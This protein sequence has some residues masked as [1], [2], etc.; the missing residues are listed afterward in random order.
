MES[1][2]RIADGIIDHRNLTIALVFI[3]LLAVSGGIVF[4]E[5]ESAMPSFTVGSDEE[6]ALD[7]IESNF[8]TRNDDVTVAQIIV[9]GENVLSKETLVSTLELQQELRANETVAGTLVEDGPTVGIANLV[10]RTAIQ[11]REPGTTDPSLSEQITILKAMDDGQI[12]AVLER[13]LGD[14]SE[15]NS[16]AY[17]L[18]PR[19]YESGSTTASATMV[20]VFQTDE[21]NAAT[22]QAPDRIVDSQTVIQS[23]ASDTDGAEMLVVGNGILTAEMD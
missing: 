11:Q 16:E 13:L 23:L 6:R 5:Q 20:A 1:L 9:K 22:G 8:S 4:L 2:E 17:A 7:D 10:A 15:A 12:D 18:L 3:V 19:D 14:D 21:I